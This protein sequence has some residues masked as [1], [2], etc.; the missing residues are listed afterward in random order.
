LK[1]VFMACRRTRR[2]ALPAAG[3]TSRSSMTKTYVSFEETAE[4]GRAIWGWDAVAF[5]QR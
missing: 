2:V 3:G 5:S 4:E 1:P